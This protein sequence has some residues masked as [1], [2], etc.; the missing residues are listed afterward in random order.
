MFRS[1]RQGRQGR[2]TSRVGNN[3]T[4][5]TSRKQSAPPKNSGQFKGSSKTDKLTLDQIYDYQANSQSRGKRLTGNQIDDHRLTG[6]RPTKDDPDL[7]IDDL[8]QIESLVERAQ[9]ENDKG[10]G[11]V[12]SD[13]DESIDSDEADGEMQERKTKPKQP[14]QKSKLKNVMKPKQ[15]DPKTKVKK[16]SSN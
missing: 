7:D 9:Q 16:V 10:L 14:A 12:Y 13:D 2:R 6:S 15:L 5:A 3:P 4:D 1:A 8:A 11:F